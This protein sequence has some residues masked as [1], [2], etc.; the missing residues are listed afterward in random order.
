MLPRWL[1]LAVAGVLVFVAGLLIPYVRAA[2]LEARL[3][4][5]TR[6]L[7]LARL[8]N[9]LA[10]AA[11][12]ARRGRYE[13]AR[14]LASDFFTGLQRPGIDMPS[15]ARDEVRAILTHRDTAITLLARGA[16]TSAD[17]LDRLIAE[18]RGVLRAADVAPERD[19]SD[20]ARR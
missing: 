17:L 6:A 1:V 16:P 14:Q 9:S 5:T 20:S 7:A 18:Y 2:R 19:H 4:R 15:A 8:E 11:L 3:E 10:M 13:S 12:E